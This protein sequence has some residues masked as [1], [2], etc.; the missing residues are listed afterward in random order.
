MQEKRLK[1]EYAH[2]RQVN[3][4]I[5]YAAQAVVQKLTP[6][7]HVSKDKTLTDGVKGLRKRHEDIV[8][9][10]KRIDMHCRR[11]LS[12][13]DAQMDKLKLDAV[14]EKKKKKAASPKKKAA[15]KKKK[16]AK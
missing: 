11:K 15:A 14:G 3:T 6:L 13:L 9:A 4:A 16:A 8:K 2:V 5:V 7:P 10:G 12:R 1:E